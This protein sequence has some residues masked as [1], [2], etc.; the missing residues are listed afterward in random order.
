MEND[1][2]F[3]AM[4]IFVGFFVLIN[5]SA[6]ESFFS[7]F[8]LC[9]GVRMVEKKVDFVPLAKNIRMEKKDQVL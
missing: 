5:K 6:D 3:E 8:F 1:I 9:V 4:P 2:P 7:Y